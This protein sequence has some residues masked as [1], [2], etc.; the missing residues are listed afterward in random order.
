[1]VAIYTWVL[2]SI[3]PTFQCRK[4]LGVAQAS[5][6]EILWLEKVH[7]TSRNQRNCCGVEGSK[8]AQSGDGTRKGWDWLFRKPLWVDTNP[9]CACWCWYSMYSFV[10]TDSCLIP[11]SI[12]AEVTFHGWMILITRL[13]G[14][15][16]A[17]LCKI[18]PN[19]DDVSLKHLAWYNW[20]DALCS[21]V[22]CSIA[23]MSSSVTLRV[24]LHA[25]MVFFK[26]GLMGSLGMSCG[27]SQASSSL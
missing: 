7:V 3:R 10:T 23:R 8:T 27:L 22:L 2:A 19:N 26:S 4:K 16:V 12:A 21:Q 25:N 11:N 17:C 6:R 24:V 18:A 14:K 20:L 5:C 9:S 15:V 13:S 1:M